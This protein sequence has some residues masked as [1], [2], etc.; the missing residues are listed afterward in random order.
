MALKRSRIPTTI[1]RVNSRSAY[2]AALDTFSPDI[3]L[4]DHSLSQFDSHAALELLRAARPAIPFIIVTG[5]LSGAL[6]GV[7]IRA[8]AE[9]VILKSD[10][11]ALPAS[12]SN[13]L[14]VRQP[15]QTLTL[16]QREVLRMIAEG[17]R[18]REIADRLGLKTKTVES[19]RYG[20]MKRLHTGSVVS[21]VRYAIR[22]GLIPLDPDSRLGS[23]TS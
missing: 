1:E 5:A 14:A 12:I 15:L 23:A 22:V 17:H 11:G 19:H 8:G 4:S 20:L 7:A 18:T 13:A 9:D 3:V 21:L 2:S 16:R 6:T 10:L